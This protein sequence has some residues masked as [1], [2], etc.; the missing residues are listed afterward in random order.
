MDE[1]PA[2]QCVDDEQCPRPGRPD[3]DGRCWFH[4]LAQS[5]VQPYRE[6][7]RL[8][9]SWPTRPPFTR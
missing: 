7:S 2:V 1:Q 8:R 4:D 5:T 6:T 9:G 3:R